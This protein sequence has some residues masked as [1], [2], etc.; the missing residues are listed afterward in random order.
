MSVETRAITQDGFNKNSQAT[1]LSNDE[2]TIFNSIVENVHIDSNAIIADEGRRTIKE[3]QL[4]K[5]AELNTYLDD[6]EDRKRGLMAIY[7]AEKVDSM[8]D[9]D[10]EAFIA[11]QLS[12]KIDTN[13]TPENSRAPKGIPTTIEIT[14]R[15]QKEGPVKLSFREKARLFMGA[16]GRAVLRTQTY[17]SN[18]AEKSAKKY[19]AMT[20]EM[21]EKH[22]KKITTLTVLGATAVI[23]AITAQKFGHNFSFGG[24]SFDQH[25]GS[26]QGAQHNSLVDSDTAGDLS[27]GSI[28]QDVNYQDF[29]YDP[30]KDPFNNPLKDEY[31]FRAALDVTTADT[32]KNDLT[33]GWKHNPLQFATVLAAFDII[34]NDQVSIEAAAQQMLE[35]P[36]LY[37]GRYQEVMDIVDISSVRITE[38]SYE[39]YGTYSMVATESAI[40]PQILT[41]DPSVIH[42]QAIL[43]IATPNGDVDFGCECGQS[44]N[45]PEVAAPEAIPQESAPVGGGPVVTRPNTI[46][47]SPEPQPE[48]VIPVGNGD[49]VAPVA[50]SAPAAPHVPVRPVTP[51]IPTIPGGGGTTPEGGGPIPGGGGTTP[52]GE[53]YDPTKIHT[54]GTETGD[55]IDP[56]ANGFI[57]DTVRDGNGNGS[58]DVTADTAPEA[59]VTGVT[60][61]GADPNTLPRVDTQ[62][63]GAGTSRTDTDAAARQ[64]ERQQE[65][66][67]AQA[68]ENHSQQQAAGDS[69]RDGYARAR[70][71]Q[72]GIGAN[73]RPKDTSGGTPSAPTDTS[74]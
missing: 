64:K 3:K 25:Q 32:A 36:E 72:D 74:N 47:T 43:T 63:A 23:G 10:V 45:R 33:E 5:I 59:D 35:D 53:T 71:E 24:F 15:L 70:A 48:A 50:P 58:P 73:G 14:E 6:S 2:N 12:P 11:E 29:I 62:E 21:K 31:S 51:N 39:P 69:D 8:S 4:E 65:A 55:G 13:N 61:P 66:V 26:G 41:Y 44:V 1:Q 67:A 22:N 28:D 57:E 46:W 16:P 27:G 52:G 38:G 68:N 34:P 18:R 19:E 42:D 37:S 54:G 60:S 20:P 40:Q 56:T 7:G 49:P 9:D 17:L 30:N